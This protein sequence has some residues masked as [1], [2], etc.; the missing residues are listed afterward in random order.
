[1]CMSLMAWCPGRWLTQSPDAPGG[2]PEAK[3][4]EAVGFYGILS[5][6]S[7]PIFF[8]EL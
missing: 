1:M 5:A 2:G 6:K 8:S 7:L 4:F 3:L